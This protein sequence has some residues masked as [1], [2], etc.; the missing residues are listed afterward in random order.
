MN[1]SLLPRLTKP[2][3]LSAVLMLATVGNATGL[4]DLRVGDHA[5][6]TRVVV[7]VSDN[8]QQ[9]I[10][11]LSN[12]DRVVIDIK[13]QWQGSGIRLPA[14]SGLIEK[15]QSGAQP[16]GDYRIV[17]HT[18]TPAAVNKYFF[19]PPAPNAG[20]PYGRLVFDLGTTSA[21]AIAQTTTY[22]RNTPNRDTVALARLVEGSQQVPLPPGQ[23][24]KNV[25]CA[26][27]CS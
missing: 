7:D 19:L 22:E 25:A 13:G 2:L 14:K 24:P 10:K 12:P 18:K 8:P 26:G 21:P 3:L 5:T 15:I 20:K 6:K 23:L 4:Y 16:N 17:L 11:R 1:F 27:R 9:K